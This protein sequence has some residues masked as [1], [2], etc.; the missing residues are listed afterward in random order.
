MCRGL[1]T[2]WR[3]ITLLSGAVIPQRSKCLQH[4]VT[5]SY[6]STTDMISG[7]A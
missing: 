2:R 4:L 1:S 6:E 7:I 5:E 3:I